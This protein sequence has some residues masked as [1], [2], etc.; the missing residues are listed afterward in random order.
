MPACS[1]VVTAARIGGVFDQG[2][3]LR[4]RLCFPPPA[5]L[6]PATS[7][8][9]AK[10]ARS[11]QAARSGEST[12]S[13]QAAQ[14]SESAGSTGPVPP[15]R[16]TLWRMQAAFDFLAGYSLP[17]VSKYVRACG[18]RLRHGRPEYYSPDPAYREKEVQLLQVLGQVGRQ[19]KKKVA[20]FI[21]EMSY[22]R[23][24][25]PSSD[26]CGQAPAPRP[27]AKRKPSRYQRYRVVAALDAKSG[28]VL[29]RQESRISG[30][31]FSRF[32]RQLDQAYPKVQ[33][34]YLIW[35]N[36]PVHSS[37]VVKQTLAE[38]PRL[39]VVRRPSYAPWLNPIEKLWRKFRQEVDYLHELAGDWKQLHERVQQFFTQ[40]APGSTDLLRYVGLSGEG[41]LAT[42]LKAGP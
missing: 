41:K 35:D 10:S 38:F 6:P 13:T 3:P 4:E 9:S 20:L 21:D 42:A 37:D 36:W 26:W 8:R 23:W 40:F 11:A 25:P 18:I 27:L 29:F 24:P 39:Q 2:E 17:G 15:S 19:P 32:L 34:I 1:R 7:A 14:S 28:R 30:E 12:E 22:T 33:T 16:W 31:V 5:G